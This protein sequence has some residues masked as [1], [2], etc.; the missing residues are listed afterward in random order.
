MNSEL[1]KYL[2]Q[3]GIGKVIAQGLADVYTSKPETPVKYLAAWLKKYSA[4]QCEIAKL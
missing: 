3:D 2:K 1:L 4:N